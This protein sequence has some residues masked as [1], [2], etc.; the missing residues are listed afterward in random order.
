[1]QINIIKIFVLIKNGS[2]ILIK[3]IIDK[4]LKNTVSLILKYSVSDKIETIIIVKNIANIMFI[5][6]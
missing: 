6:L 1:M 2:H 4:I 5:I 3:V